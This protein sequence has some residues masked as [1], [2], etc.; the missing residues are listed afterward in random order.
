MLPL[1]QL[2]PAGF[3]KQPGS[4]QYA[5]AYQWLHRE[6]KDTPIGENTLFLEYLRAFRPATTRDF[7]QW[8]GL[9]AQEV[10]PIIERC[11]RWLKTYEDEVGN[12]LYDLKGAVLPDADMKVPPRLLPRWDN[13][14]LAYEN[15]SRVMSESYR[16]HVIQRDG[17]VLPTV[18]IDGY[19]Q[20]IWDHE[21]TRKQ[22]RMSIQLFA[23]IEEDMC[24]ALHNEANR[25]L[26]FLCPQSAKHE[27]IIK[28]F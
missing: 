15:R 27:M 13:L 7:Q 8:S 24:E 20:G 12:T 14:L 28:G 1:V 21:A 25:L 9:N 5:L 23:G 19:V 3:L 11:S 18:L 17:R 16:E 26:T 10:K 2:P 6:L 4:P 22:A